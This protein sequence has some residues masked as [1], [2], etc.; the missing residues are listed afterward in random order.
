MDNP[1]VRVGS[2]L[3]DFNL[4]GEHLPYPDNLLAQPP[5]ETAVFITKFLAISG[6]VRL[7]L[8]FLQA[9]GRCAALLARGPHTVRE[10]STKTGIINPVRRIGADEQRNHQVL[11]TETL[12]LGC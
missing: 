4:R 10:Y 2:K 7:L 3:T 1:N 9:T 6:N 5:L 8:M 11:I 12:L